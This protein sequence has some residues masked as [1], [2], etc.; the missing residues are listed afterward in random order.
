MTIVHGKFGSYAKLLK[1]STTDSG[2]KIAS[3]E[4]QFPRMVLAEFNTHAMLAKNSASSRAIPFDKMAQQLFA[5]PTRFGEKNKGMQDKGVDFDGLVVNPFEVQEH[6]GNSG[7][8]AH[9][10]AEAW[11]EAKKYALGWAEAFY[12]AGFHKQVYNRLTEP[13]QMIKTVVTATELANFFWLRD[14]EAADP[15]IAELASLTRQCLQGAEP[16]LL[17]PGEWHLPYVETERDAEGEL[18]YF[19]YEDEDFTPTYLKLEDAIKVSAA[20]SAAVSFRN[21][22]YDLEKSEEVHARLVGDDRKHA[23]AMEHQATPIQG[24]ALSAQGGVVE[25]LNIP[26]IPET[27]EPGISH[28]DRNL[29]LWSGKFNGWIQYRKLIPGE[30]VPGFGL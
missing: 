5:R 21:V 17:H 22:D 30:N 20:R 3:F 29:D 1:Y 9:F 18:H 6:E 4:V 12:K 26:A 13:F 11:E 8:P 16:Q 2:R 15:T 27:W 24:S 25:A 7:A 23:S 19:I 28:V 14:H 10:A